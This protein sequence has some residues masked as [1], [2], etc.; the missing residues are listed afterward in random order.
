MELITLPNNGYYIY[1]VL[2]FSVLNIRKT[3]LLNYSL[4]ENIII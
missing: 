4:K 2:T 3:S 1:I